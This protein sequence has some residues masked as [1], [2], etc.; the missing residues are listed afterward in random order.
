MAGKNTAVF[1]IYPDRTTVEEASEHFLTAGFRSSDISVLFADNAGTKDFGHEKETKA[2]EGATIG[3]I[4]GLLAGGLLGWPIGTGMLGAGRFG[5]FEPMIALGPIFAA[6]AAAAVGVVIGG[7]IGSVIGIG[8]PEYEAKRYGGRIRDGGI[9]YSVHCDNSAWVK[10]AKSIMA[11]TGAQD[12]ASAAEKAGDFANTEK[13]MPRLRKSSGSLAIKA[14][15]W[16]GDRVRHDDS[17]EDAQELPHGD[18]RD[19]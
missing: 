17:F 1:G 14:K 8:I 12:I 3:G 11:D 6:L 19:L 5:G 16:S 13:P 2:P 18:N 7:I 15:D 4:I 10:R 9:L